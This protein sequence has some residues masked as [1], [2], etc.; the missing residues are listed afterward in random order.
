MSVTQICHLGCRVCNQGG[1]LAAVAGQRAQRSV[2]DAQGAFQIRLKIILYLL[3]PA[4]TT[5]CQGTEV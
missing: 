4:Q 1:T 5:V 2:V 3:K